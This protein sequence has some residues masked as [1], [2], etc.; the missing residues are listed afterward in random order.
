MSD[1]NPTTIP[2]GDD[3]YEVVGDDST[4]LQTTSA[5]GGATINA[6]QSLLGSLLW[7]ERCSRPD[8]AFS[9]HKSDA[10]AAGARLEA[11]QA[12]CAVPQENRGAQSLDG[13]DA[14]DS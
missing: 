5:S 2:I 14:N 8:I 7:V 3:C 1:A 12:H 6:F 11:R 4:L 10:R 13:T 9:V